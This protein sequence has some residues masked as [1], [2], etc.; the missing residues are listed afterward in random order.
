MPPCEPTVL[1]GDL[2]AARATDLAECVP[3]IDTI[4]MGS[5]TVFIG[6]LMAARIGDPCAHGG[7]IVM[8]EPTVI[9]GDGGSGS[10]SNAMSD[11]KQSGSPFVQDCGCT[12]GGASG[13]DSGGG[14]DSGF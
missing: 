8:G 5:P 3:A 13:G 7:V 14:D 12:G 11:A 2:P 1:I 6:N 9:I 4:V 10:Q